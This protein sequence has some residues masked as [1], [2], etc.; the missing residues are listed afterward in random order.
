MKKRILLPIALLLVLILS[1]TACS[2]NLG[3]KIDS[4]TIVSGAPAEVYIGETPDFSQIKLLAKYNDLS[5]VELGYDDVTISPVDTSRSGKVDYTITYDGLEITASLE[6]K[7]PNAPDAPVAATLTSL[8]YREGLKLSIYENQPFDTSALKLKATY[9]DESTKIVKAE[10]VKFLTEIDPKK[11]GEQILT[12]AYESLTLDITITVIEEL[13][14]A[15][16]VDAESVDTTVPVGIN[17][18]ISGLKV[19]VIYNSGTRMLIAANDPLLDADNFPNA[20]AEER[21]WVITYGDLSTTIKISSTAPVVTGIKVNS[22]YATWVLK[23]EAYN[24]GD[25]SATVTSSNNTS[26]KVYASDLVLSAVV[27]TEAGKKTVTVTYTCADGTFTDTYEIDVVF[28]TK[29][30]ID[31]GSINTQPMVGQFDDSKLTVDLTL[32]NGQYLDRSEGITVS[33]SEGFD[34]NKACVGTITATFQGVASKPV[35][36][37]V[38][39]EDSKYEV[40]G[41]ANPDQIAN[42]NSY[43][44]NFL[45]SG[46]VYAVGSNNPFKYTLNVLFE[47]ANGDPVNKEVGYTGLSEVLLEGSPAGENY[48]TIDDTNHTFQFTKAAEGKTFVIKTRPRYIDDSDIAE[49]TRTLTVTVVDAYNVHNAKE[50]NVITNKSK[51]LGSS[52]HD[53]LTAVNDFLTRHHI[54]RPETLN[55]VVLHNNF[56]L[57]LSDI[58]AEYIFKGGDGNNYIWDQ[59][60]IYYYEMQSAGT[61]NFYGNYFTIDTKNIPIV[62]PDGTQTTTGVLTND[63]DGYS[64]SEVFRFNVEESLWYNENFN[65][66]DYTFN[67][68]ALGMNDNDQSVAVQN[69]VAQQRSRLG[70]Y[71]FKFAKAVYNLNAVNATRYYITSMPEYDCVTM[72]LNYTKFYDSWQTHI[73]TWT[74][75]N[76]DIDYSGNSPKDSDTIHKYHAPTTININNSFVAKA[77]GPAI[78]GMNNLTSFH[79][80]S[81]SKPVVNIDANSQVFSYVVGDESWFIANNVADKAVQISALDAAFQLYGAR[82]TT[83]FAGSDSA[84][85]NMIMLNMDADYIPGKN[86]GMPNDIDGSLTIADTK[87]M[88]MDDCDTDGDGAVDS[89]YGKKDVHNAITA[90]FGNIIFDTSAGGLARSDLQNFYPIKTDGLFQGNYLNLYWFNL[91]ITLGFNETTAAEP[92]P[93]AAPLNTTARAYN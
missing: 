66:K 7:V 55:G 65:H 11:V 33:Y 81:Q 17:P 61:F 58:P 5:E 37:T 26:K 62:A 90:N 82:F 45:D 28:V 85:M 75:N 41:V 93:P 10:N 68:Y 89:G 25:I 34:K 59:Q 36:I 83:K 54:T 46:Y 72:N 1:L 74:E 3:K 69:P 80:N 19:Y 9:S 50:L 49:F 4:L 67:I 12:V 60:A 42:W 73:N 30:E 47:D 76:I 20:N 86:D 64:S 2:G 53:Q 6:V 31:A 14:V 16:E 23:G 52:G 70:V 92:T 32:S 39:A 22:G 21:D 43:R 57:E 29:V 44:N 88:D 35:T 40:V 8:V 38:L 84:Y 63:G 48:V 87:I 56:K 91:G 27:T 71:A 77:G 24:A 79:A 13:A 18:D 78:I 15:I 51:S